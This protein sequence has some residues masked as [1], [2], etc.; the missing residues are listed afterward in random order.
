[1]S[2]HQAE[3]ALSLLQALSLSLDQ[4]QSREEL[5]RL[6]LQYLTGRSPLVMS[7]SSRQL[8]ASSLTLHDLPASRQELS[9]RTNP[10]KM[11][12]LLRTSSSPASLFRIISEKS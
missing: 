11:A 3:L 9:D 2:S 6:I 8:L 7:S 1:M 4:E 10:L 12:R 5:A